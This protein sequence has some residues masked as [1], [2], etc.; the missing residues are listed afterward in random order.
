MQHHSF[1][2]LVHGRLSHFLYKIH[3]KRN[4]IK[5]QLCYH[6]LQLPLP[7][8]CHLCSLKSPIGSLLFVFALTYFQKCLGLSLQAIAISFWLNLSDICLSSFIS[9]DITN[10]FVRR[11]YLRVFTLNIS[12]PKFTFL[13]NQITNAGSDRLF[14]CWFFHDEKGKL[15]GTFLST[16]SSIFFFYYLPHIFNIVFT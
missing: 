3:L 1:C 2:Y 15:L 7:P 4:C 9:D 14:P 10:F 16:P 13:P 6:S 5:L 8:H 12:F 11:Q